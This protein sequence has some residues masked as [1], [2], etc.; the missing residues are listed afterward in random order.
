[1]KRRIQ[2][3]QQ[4]HVHIP[5]RLRRVLYLSA[6]GIV[7]VFIVINAVLWVI[8][9]ERT[10]PRTSV[11]N[12]SIGSTPYGSLS[13]KVNEQKLLP[14]TLKLTHGSQETAVNLASFGITKDVERTV[15]S[16]NQQRSWLPL[17]NLFKSPELRAPVTVDRDTLTA[18]AKELA[19]VIRQDAV[20]ARLALTGATV[21]IA[22][23]K[24]GYVLE[25]NE[26]KTAIIQA[27]DG[28]KT[29]LAAPTE[30]LAPKVTADALQDDKQSLEAQLNVAL[31][32]K[33]GGKSKQPTREDIAKWYMQSGESY[34]LSQD[35]IRAY[36]TQVGSD[37]GIRV[38]DSSQ[39]AAA[40]AQAITDRK[41]TTITLTAQIAVKTY[42]YCTAV[43]G[44]DAS[45]LPALRSKLRAAFTDSRG[46][47]L[48]GLVEYTEV[49][50][51]CN[52]TVWLSA[53]E[54]MPTFGAICDA[55]WSCRVG[56]NVVINYD[57][58][59]NA[60]PA[61]NAAG[62]SLEEYRNMVINHETGHW[63]GFGHRNCSG[64]GQA[65]P[66]MQQQSINLQGCSFN[67]WPVAAELATLRQ[68]LGI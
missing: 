68:K 54:L 1:M 4:R 9:R 41:A 44:V 10:Y 23:A 38:K 37:F 8:Y 31:T 6:A 62:G 47:S 50:S 5:P 7:G 19:G 60:S 36:I 61:W 15:R 43:K 12:T 49:T 55:M 65:A 18:K 48:N 51:G 25:Q 42:A 64:T 20:N 57:R 11:M 16:A 67:A 58:W 46:W 66:V 2:Q 32:Y 17:V 56:T 30:R 3:R 22:E 29:T 52:F 35:A 24:N 21:S 27:L 26:L 34:T 13:Q 14:A 63:L 59:T 45:H 39:A 53:P 40:T 33:Y 28:G